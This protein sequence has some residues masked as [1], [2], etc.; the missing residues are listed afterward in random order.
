MVEKGCA[1]MDA[2]LKTKQG[3]NGQN[4]QNNANKTINYFFSSSN[5]DADKRKSSELMQEIHNIF[6]MYSMALGAFKAHS[7]YSLSKTANCIKH[8]PGM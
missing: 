3:A 6:G 4:G 2:D 8:H 5:V 1:N 7:L